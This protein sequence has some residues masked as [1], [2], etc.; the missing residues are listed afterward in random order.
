VILSSSFRSGIEKNGYYHPFFLRGMPTLVS[1]I[2]RVG[3]KGTGSR[4]PSALPSAPNF[5][6][7]EY[8]GETATESASG[9]T[10]SPTRNELPIANVMVPQPQ[11]VQP[12]PG[13]ID[14]LARF[15]QERAS[16][17]VDSTARLSGAMELGPTLS[18]LGLVHETNVEAALAMLRQQRI[19]EQERILAR[20][21]RDASQLDLAVMAVLLR[22]RHPNANSNRMP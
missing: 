14:I 21:L 15:D 16:T 4:S 10:L 1:N 6:A 8:L 9:R 11:T 18:R 5:Y 7:L 19:C 12:A 17:L 20:F 22:N 13:A 3:V 2:A